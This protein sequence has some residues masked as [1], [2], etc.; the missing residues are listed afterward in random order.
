MKGYQSLINPLHKVKSFRIQSQ[1]YGPHPVA[2]QLPALL[3][4]DIEK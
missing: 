1:S 3:Q 2:E 4:P